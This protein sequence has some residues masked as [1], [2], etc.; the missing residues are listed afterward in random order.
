MAEKY[1]LEEIAKELESINKPLPVSIGFL[2][3]FNSGKSTLIN[4]LLGERLLPAMEVPTSKSIVEIEILESQHDREYFTKTEVGELDS[5]SQN[6]FREIALGKKEGTAVCRVRSNEIVKDGFKI[7]DTPGLGSL[8]DMDKDITFGYL[9][10][11]DGAVLCWNIE[12]G[13][14]TESFY[15]FLR[16]DELGNITDNF[17]FVLTHA[18][19]KSPA[20]ME[21]IRRSVI[22]GLQN[23]SRLK[24]SN[25]ETKVNCIDSEEA[26][27]S[28]DSRLLKGFVDSFRTNIVDRKQELMKTRIDTI[29]R[30]IQSRILFILEDKLRNY[31]L[32][33]EEFD[34]KKEDLNK[35]KR[36]LEKM[37]DKQEDNFNHL[38]IKLQG[39]ITNMIKQYASSLA[40]ATEE[41]RQQTIQV[42]VSAIYNEAN[43]S[44]KNY[45]ENLSVSLG[46]LGPVFD[47]V[48][49]NLKS[50]DQLTEICKTICTAVLTTV[51]LPGSSAV[52][53]VGEAGAG[54][55]AQKISTEVA[56]QTVK[57]TAKET[58]KKSFLERTFLVFAKVFKETNPV[59]HIGNYLSLKYKQN[60]LDSLLAG[61]SSQISESL[62]TNLREIFRSEIINPIRNDL[63]ELEKSIDNVRKD[64]EQSIKEQLAL[65][66][67]LQTDIA[68]L[69]SINR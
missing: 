46:D 20:A 34:E 25:L 42:I 56:K 8:D 24:I 9:Q 54:A 3:E 66:E 4:A 58:A 12:K 31:E 53:T 59:E 15:E 62:V 27:N 44:I 67:Q 36:D 45:F 30:N 48:N 38:R 26:L 6:E 60:K 61:A 10:F 28:G 57:T 64:K 7:V 18:A 5:I 39:S 69:S 63:Y 19:K 29:L 49:S 52:A 40:A 50:I 35:K 22:E 11:L 16:K 43:S 41:N 13:N 23:Y 2:G 37:I 1:H 51:I 17:L 47:R 21:E 55:A 32:S 68:N 65:R 33:G 14:P